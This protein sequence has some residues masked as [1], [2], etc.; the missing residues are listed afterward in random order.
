MDDTTDRILVVDDEEDVHL[1]CRVTLEL[2][3]YHV[4]AVANGAEALEALRDEPTSLV[5]LD[6]MMPVMDGWTFL[7]AVRSDPRLRHTPVVML[8]AKVRSTD[9][10][11][12][13]SEGAVDYVTKPFH[14]STVVKT[15]R[16]V[17]ETSAAE[18]DSRR[19]ERL[20]HLKLLERV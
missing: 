17:L 14:P 12:G 7:R 6:V 15:V 11:R 20:R 18:R 3:G 13:L 2:E 16:E 5:L 8:T 19:K 1:L 4:H 10:V 9:Q